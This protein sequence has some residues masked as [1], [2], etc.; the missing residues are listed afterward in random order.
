MET[1]YLN[2]L[3]RL[4]EA[5]GESALWSDLRQRLFVDPAVLKTDYA[6]SPLWIRSLTDAWADGLNAYLAD[7]PDVKPKVITRFEPWMALSFTEGS[8]GGDIER[9]FLPELQVF[10]DRPQAAARAEAAARLA[11]AENTKRF[12]EPSGSNGI[13]IAPS[14]TADG[15]ALLLINPHTSFYFRSEL[16]MSSDE[17]LDAY[18]AA[19]WGQFFIYQG[20][21]PHIGWMHTSTGAD[22][23]DKFAET[24]VPRDGRLLYRYGRE[25]LPVSTASITLPYRRAD[26]TMASRTFT[27]YRT[28]HGPIVRQAGGKWIALA[29]MDRP[30]AA[31]SQ[32]YLRT[33][34]HDYASFL[35]IAQTY[36]ANS[37]N[38]TVFAD[39]RGEIALLMPQFIPR[40]DDRFDYTAPVDGADPPLTGRA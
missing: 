35:N 39:D 34:A 28:H 26:G 36:R 40:R 38:N 2:A 19:T 27:V 13:A 33:K 30:V 29:L 22:A 10:Y 21:N 4:A 3:G 25:L 23:V 14:N 9:A 24:I 6:A 8:I 11:D 7:H 12:M 32:S 16:Q 20:F 17:G 15:H 31:L 5:E 18:G 37:S 1:N